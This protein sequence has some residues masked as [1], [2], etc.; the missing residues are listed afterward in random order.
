MRVFCPPRVVYGP[1]KVPFFHSASSL[2]HAALGFISALGMSDKPAPF[3]ARAAGIAIAGGFLAYQMN[4]VEPLP[5]KVGD[6]GEF[7]AGF[8]AGLLC[9]K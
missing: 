6:L 9:G 8:L 1:V 4:E 3:G 2:G 5:S 7:G